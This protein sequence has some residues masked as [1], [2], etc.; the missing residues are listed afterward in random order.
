MS[1][2]LSIAVYSTERGYFTAIFENITERK[3]AEEA[4]RESENKFR[5]LAETSPAAIFLYQGEKYIYVNPMAQT[6]T[7]YSREELLAEDAW[8]WIHTDFQ[9][10]VKER[11]IGRQLGEQLPTRYEVKYSSKDGREGWVDFTAGRVEYGG[12]PAGLAMAFDITE[13]KRVEEALIKSKV[14]A[15]LYIDLMGHD[16]NNMHQVALG[17]LELARDMPAGEGQAMFLD[18]PV[19]VLQRST[20]LI[21]NVRKLQKLCDGVFKTELVDVCK[22]LSDVQRES[23]AVPN[24]RVM[25][26]FNGYERRFVRANELLYDVFANLVSNAIKHT[27]DRADIIVDLDI[28]KDNGSRYYRVMV[29]DNGPGIPDDFKATIFNRTLKGTNN[30]KGMGLG[31][32]LAKSLVDSYNGRVWVEDRIIGDHTKGARFVVIIPA[33]EK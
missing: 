16:I 23:G 10:M 4:L 17:Y 26:N 14:Q 20:L 33:V 1:S 28:V 27:G 12:K 32:Y 29:E 11:A 18:K 7:G 8:G 3:R 31:L 22:V 15:E 2:W 19:E 5:V 9:H 6:L 24:K 25:L 30:A 21:Q 13:R